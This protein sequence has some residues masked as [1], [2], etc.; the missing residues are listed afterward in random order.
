MIKI[1]IIREAEE[2]LTNQDYSPMEIIEGV[3]LIELKRFTGADGAF[4]ELVRIEKGKVVVPKE[5]KGFAVKQ[6][7]H[8]R[9]VPGSVKA[10]HC[11]FNQDE[12]WFI[13]PE[14]KALVGLSDLRAK[15]KTKKLSMKLCLGDGRAHLLYIPRGVAHGLSNPYLQDVTMTYLV[16]NWFDGGDEKR[17]RYNFL[18]GKGFWEIDKG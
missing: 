4:N 18:V 3:E 13:H 11:H 2:I 5:L 10:W 12:V 17:L 14:S 16:N 6:I 9:V 15:S 8:S 7:N 1:K